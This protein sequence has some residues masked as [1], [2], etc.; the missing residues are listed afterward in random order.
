[1]RTT[2]SDEQFRHELSVLLKAEGISRLGV[3]DIA[4]R[5]SCSRRRLYQ[6]APTKEGLLTT[7]AEEMFADALSRGFA[8]ARM[9]K[10]SAKRVLAYLRVGSH[11][12]SSLSEAFLQDLDSL[13]EACAAFDRYQI[14]RANGLRELI[15][16]GI[17]EGE[18]VPCN[19]RLLAEVV[20]GA[21]LRL[22]RPEFLHEIGMS[23]QE[24]FEEAA[25]LI[26]YGML[27][28]HDVRGRAGLSKRGRTRAV[29]SRR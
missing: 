17:C 13:P 29:S 20:L 19:A 4:T 5:L 8:A 18:F 22:R 28:A 2:R 11:I 24:A 1:M 3:A 9:E 25:E 6:V 15:E 14:A 26:V 7:V 21:A 23:L 10:G 16:Q 12:A 27:R